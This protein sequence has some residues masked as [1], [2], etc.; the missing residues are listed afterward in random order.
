MIKL[1]NTLQLR[2]RNETPCPSFSVR[3]VAELGAEPELVS[4]KSSIT[5]EQQVDTMCNL[6]G[7]KYIMGQQSYTF[8]KV[9][10]M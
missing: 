10:Y 6:S 8:M 4:D 1:Q 3:R 9:S 5:S 2:K 7:L